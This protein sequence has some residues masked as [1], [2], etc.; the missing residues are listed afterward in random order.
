M[1]GQ[2]NDWMA[3]SCSALHSTHFKRVAAWKT[4]DI[5]NTFIIINMGAEQRIL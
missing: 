4:V 5:A 1:A 3:S 2:Q